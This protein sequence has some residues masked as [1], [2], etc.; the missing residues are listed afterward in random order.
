MSNE[1]L[2]VNDGEEAVGNMEEFERVTEP[3]PKKRNA[4][5][6]RPEENLEFP[7]NSLTFFQVDPIAILAIPSTAGGSPTSSP[8]PVVT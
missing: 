5:G 2:V 1:G 4:N 6:D 8:F 7:I 3:D